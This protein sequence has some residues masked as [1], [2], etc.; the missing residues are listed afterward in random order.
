MR[1]TFSIWRVLFYGS[2][3]YLISINIFLSFMFCVFSFRNSYY[4]RYWAFYT[5]PL[6]FLALKKKKKV[7]FYLFVPVFREISTT[8]S[9]KSLVEFL[10]YSVFNYLKVFTWLFLNGLLLLFHDCSI[11]SDFFEDSSVIGLQVFLCSLHTLY[12]L[13]APWAPFSVIF[14]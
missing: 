12:F 14:H 2:K 5:H 10:Y 1:S 3:K 4:F 11:F 13:W 6:T 8:W 7:S 9:F